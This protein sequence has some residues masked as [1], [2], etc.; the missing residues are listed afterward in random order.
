MPRSRD[1]LGP[2]M[3]LNVGHL[4]QVALQR[5]ANRLRAAK[6]PL[7][8]LDEHAAVDPASGTVTRMLALCQACAGGCCSSLRVPITRSDAR[9]LA[10]HLGV[11]ARALPLH[12]PDGDEDEPDDLAG[13]LTH[14]DRPCPYF[15]RGCTVHVAR[16]DV[17]RSFGLHG[18]MRAGT[19]VPRARLARGPSAP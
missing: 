14:G 1:P 13:Y 9:R 12:P 8:A 19:F 10:R 5:L 2:L 16:P 3:D 4:P 15:D 11:Q 7:D 17:C 18:C 6:I